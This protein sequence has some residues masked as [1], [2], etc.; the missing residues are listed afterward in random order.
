MDDATL[1]LLAEK[2]KIIASLLAANASL[3]KDKAELADKYTDLT[4]R[5]T[6]VNEENMTLKE[7]LAS[8]QA[9]LEPPSQSASTGTE[10]TPAWVASYDPDW[11][12]GQELTSSLPLLDYDC[13]A[14]QDPADSS[15]DCSAD[16]SSVSP[17]DCSSDNGSAVSSVDWL[18]EEPAGSSYGWDPVKEP[19]ASDWPVEEL[20]PTSGDWDQSPAAL[21]WPEKPKWQSLNLPPKTDVWLTGRS[22]LNPHAMDPKRLSDII[23]QHALVPATRLN[24][25]GWC[26][27][28]LKDVRV[29]DKFLFTLATRGKEV[30]QH[31]IWDHARKHHPSVQQRYW[32][33]GAHQIKMEFNQLNETVAATDAFFAWGEND[34]A[35]ARNALLYKVVQLR[36][37]VA[38]W[39]HL[40]G[41]ST[42]YFVDEHLEWVQKFAITMGN[43]ERAREARA[44]RDELRDAVEGTVAE[45]EGLE[46]TFG[47]CTFK[48]HHVQMFRQIK[49]PNELVYHGTVRFPDVV[50]RAAEAWARRLVEVGDEKDDSQGEEDDDQEDHKTDGNQD[51]KKAGVR[52]RRNSFNGSGRDIEKGLKRRASFLALRQNTRGKAQ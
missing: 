9:D 23:Y 8:H 1:R 36:H 16:G 45:L 7:K 24:D 12:T 44:L 29:D 27:S 38:H 13:E 30:A 2:D 26:T 4:D 40:E 51:N 17:D 20:A 22:W 10:D 37:M 47:V 28:G 49:D 34:P 21:G 6:K 18:V 31:T 15:D 46:P 32:P 14:Q 50:L 33:G 19:G 41:R 39:D 52:R 42:A 35:Q 25:K 11:C 5:Y 3:T 48:L 43:E